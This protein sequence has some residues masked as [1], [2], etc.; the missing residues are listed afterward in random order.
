MRKAGYELKLKC[1]TEVAPTIVS[2]STIADSA[3]TNP[4]PTP[5]N[6]IAFISQAP[7]I[8]TISASTEATPL[9]ESTPN[10][11]AKTSDASDNKSIN[12]EVTKRK[13]SRSEKLLAKMYPNFKR[14]DEPSSPASS[15]SGSG[16]SQLVA[17]LLAIFLGLLGI[18]RFYLGYIGIGII[19][20]LTGGLF[21]IWWIIDIIMIATGNLKPKN[22]DYTDKL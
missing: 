19:Q 8:N 5:E 13:V 16:K 9:V 12:A 20:L 14:M 22:E 11:L 17:L 7:N 3:K 21:G 2:T 15:S 10:Y 6:K 18:H 4:T 1:D